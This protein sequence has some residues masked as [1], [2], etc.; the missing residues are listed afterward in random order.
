MDLKFLSARDPAS[1]SVAQASALI[2]AGELSPSDLLQAVLDRI[3]RVDGRIYSYLRFDEDAARDAAAAATVRCEQGKRLG[4]LDGIPFAVKDN[5]YTAGMPTTAASRVP[6][7]HDPSLHATLVARLQA[8]GAVL[9][10]KL[11]TWEYG[12]GTGAVHFDL[13]TP[14]AYNPWNPEHFTGGSSSGAGAAVAAGTAC[15]AI[16]TDT[17]G[18]VRLPAAACGVVGLK[19]TFGRVSRHGVMR[20]CASFDT[21]GPLALTVEDACLVYEALAGHDPADPVSLAEAVQPV[22]PT[23]N[24]GVVGLRVGVVRRMDPTSGVEAEIDEALT[25]A[26]KVLLAQ[27]AELRDI[28]LPLAPAEFRAVTA[29]IN[30]YECYSVHEQDY[31]AHADAMG[32]S[33][34][35]KLQIGKDI[36]EHDYQEALRKRHELVARVD[37][38]FDEVD[39]LLVPMTD[40]VAPA[41]SDEQS[42]IDF[43]TRSAGSLF[44]LT[45]HPA[46]SVPAGFT[47][48]GLPIAVQL[49]AGF[50]Q[51]AR[52][53]RAARTL[54]RHFTPEPRRARV[55]D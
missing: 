31:L 25:Q 45:G 37:G 46:V 36:R 5:I 35:E 27:G 49:A 41:F 32:R 17:G 3:K 24:A 2:D 23:L 12:T 14:P 19:P 21:V 39:L 18:S 16:G 55:F 38:L 11:N 30:R 48:K 50:L 29:P 43:T 6:Q 4:P 15:F 33:L 9:I 44:S 51:E 53:M 42:V 47:A 13:D 40:R 34:R 7:R 26:S 52:L 1:F 8:A 20:N 28:A 54:E 10:G 22:L